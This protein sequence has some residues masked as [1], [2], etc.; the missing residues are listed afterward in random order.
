M[1]DNKKQN[2]KNLLDE[3]TDLQREKINEQQQEDVRKEY[4]SF[5]ENVKVGK[6]YLCGDYFSKLDEDK[7]CIHWL[8]GPFGPNEFKKNKHFHLVYERFAFH[9]MDAY[10]RWLANYEKPMTNINDLDEGSDKIIEHTI[11]Y[12]NIEWSFSCSKGDFQG[13][14]DSFSG[15]YPH[16][17]FQM[18]VDN[19][20]VISFSEFHVPFLDYDHF[21]F[22]V[23]NGELGEKVRHIGGNGAGSKELFENLKEEDL[24]LLRHS[25]NEKDAPFHIDTFLIAKPGQGIKSED[26]N[27]L[28][29]E[30]KKT[31]KTFAELSK[32]IKEANRQT[33]I[34][35]GDGIPEKLKRKPKMRR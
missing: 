23:K 34:S 11:L 15:K 22:A 25:E 17:H 19:L 21:V 29:E 5:L 28:I 10:F 16:Y 14:K 3:M 30:A 6:C 27:K 12:K 31:G 26:I 18:R 4:E 24:P 33:I 13:H 1:E 35:P 9:Q 8:L 7:S 32:N 20:P 2:I